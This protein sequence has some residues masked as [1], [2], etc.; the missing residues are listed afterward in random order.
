VVGGETP[1]LASTE[2]YAR[3][4]ELHP[5]F[6]DDIE[7]FGVKYIRYMPEEDD[8]TSAIGV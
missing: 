1:L 5:Q 2:M 4:H 6:M 3:M 7:T 8:P